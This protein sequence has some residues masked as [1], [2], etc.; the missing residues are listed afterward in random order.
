MK[1][2]KLQKV[3]KQW[4]LIKRRKLKLIKSLL[5]RKFKKEAAFLSV[6]MAQWRVASSHL[7]LEESIRKKREMWSVECPLSEMSGII[8]RSATQ[9]KLAYG[10]LKRYTGPNSKQTKRK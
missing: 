9:N 2:Y 8:V 10:Q 4:K 7:K 5:N 3:F 6:I 1:R